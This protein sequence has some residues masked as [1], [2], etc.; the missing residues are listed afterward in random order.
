MVPEREA[1]LRGAGASLVAGGRHQALIGRDRAGWLSTAAAFIQEGVRRQEPACVGVS[2]AAGSR[3]RETVGGHP[4][5]DYF[6]MAEVGR[7]PGRIIPAMLDF[8]ARHPGR[9]LRYVSEPCWA[10]RSDAED[11]EAARHEALLDLAFTGISATILCGYDAG[12]LAATVL[13]CAEQTHS[14]IISGGRPQASERYAGHAVLPPQ[15]DP[16]L[17]RPPASAVALS[18]GAGLR[19][20]RSHVRACARRAGLD[21]DKATDMVLVVSEVA[22]NTLRH[23]DGQGRL[24]IWHTRAEMV[25]QI[26]DSGRIEDPLAGRRARTD[27]S[28]HGLWVVNQVCDLV[29]LR[30]GP[31]G[32]TVRMHIRL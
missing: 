16:P 10:G 23:A 25:C 8:A 13:S 9:P 30:S 1:G 2:A 17:S 22:A 14:V 31:E 29:Q 12:S 18:Y 24:L 7:N 20:V 19:E 26:T 32:T 5:V 27:G 3:L 11:A 28:G 21:S 6:D 15:C 4:T